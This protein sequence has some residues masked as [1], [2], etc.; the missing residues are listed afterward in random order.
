MKERNDAIIMLNLY[1]WIK[2]EHDEYS[3]VVKK[4]LVA[5]LKV[6]LA[7]EECEKALGFCLNGCKC[8]GSLITPLIHSDILET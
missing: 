2:F 5:S 6:I 8:G 7:T 1:T 3:L 4:V